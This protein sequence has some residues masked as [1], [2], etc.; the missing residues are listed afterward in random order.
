MLEMS[1]DHREPQIVSFDREALAVQEPTFVNYVKL[2]FQNKKVRRWFHWYV[3]EN[4]KLLWNRKQKF[5]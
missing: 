1:K 5:K 3:V 4:F 2:E